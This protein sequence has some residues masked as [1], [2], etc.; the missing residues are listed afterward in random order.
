MHKLFLTILPL[1]GSCTGTYERSETSC[2]NSSCHY[3]LPAGL[4]VVE[5]SPEAYFIRLA[6]SERVSELIIRST[7]DSLSDYFDRIDFCLEDAHERGDEYL[8]LIG[9]TVYDHENDEIYPLN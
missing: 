4:S 8:S 3:N 5:Q 9:N 2:P 6:S 7:A 1:L